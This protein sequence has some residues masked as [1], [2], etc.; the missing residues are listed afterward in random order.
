M[1][2]RAPPS[3][4]AGRAKRTH[5]QKQGSSYSW[6]SHSMPAHIANS[7]TKLALGPKLFDSLTVCNAFALVM[8]ALLTA[9]LFVF[10]RKKLN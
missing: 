10:A 1:S 8:F 3:L 2:D 9:P 7:I 5:A 6:E 4:T